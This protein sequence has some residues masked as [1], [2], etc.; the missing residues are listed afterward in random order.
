MKRYERPD[1]VWVSS[2]IKSLQKKFIITNMLMVFFVLASV[3]SIFTASNYK[4]AKGESERALHMMLNR[5]DDT[6]PPLFEIGKKPPQDFTLSPVFLIKVGTN[7]EISMIHGDHI[8]ISARDLDSIGEQVLSSPDDKGLI[9]EYNLRFQ[10]RREGNFY[11]AA[12]I[13]ISSEQE[14][15]QHSLIQSFLLMTVTMACFFLISAFLSRWALKPAENAW[16]Q[17]KRFLSDASHE[18]KTPLTVILANTDILEA[19]SEDTIRTQIKWIQN[20]KK[21]ALRM[22][23]L[24]NQMLFLAK[25]DS[26]RIPDR[27]TAVNLSELLLSTAL[28]FES[29]AYE[30]KTVFDTERIEESIFITGDE[31]QLKQLVSILIDNAVKYSPDRS[32]IALNLEK[33]GS[34]AVCKISNPGT[35][36]SKQEIKHIFDRFYRCDESRAEEGYGLGLSIAQSIVH[37]HKGRIYAQSVGGINTFLVQ[38]QFK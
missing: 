20:T 14:V 9:K 31:N 36:L 12:F 27:H 1:T 26:H 38:F 4:R 25:S 3:F 22:K 6:L 18:L 15:L 13:D 30:K 16:E 7:A 5:R 35:P 23:Q 10:K 33:T 34:R 8:S 19:N 29:V 21:E 17:Q 11:R 28:A 32:I 24:V 2:M 37:S